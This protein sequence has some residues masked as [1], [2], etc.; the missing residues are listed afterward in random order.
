MKKNCDVVIIGAGP[1]GLTCAAYLA[2]AGLSVVVL[3]ARH[4]TGGGL[5]TLE[6]GGFKHNLHAIY[7]MM[8]EIMP[9][10][11]DFRLAEKGVRYIYPEVQA[12]YINPGEKPV[13]LYRDPERTAGY[14]SSAFGSDQGKNYARMYADFKEFSDK[15]L[16]PCTYV[17]SVPPIEQVQIL[18]RAKDDVGR[19]FNEVAELTPMEMLDQ[20]ELADPVRAAVLNLFT[21]WGLSPFEA[22]GYIFPLYVYRMTNA[23]LCAGGSHRLSSALYKTVLAAGGEIWDRMPV[24]RVILE[25]GRAAGVVT[26]DGT[27]IR[28]RAVAS[29]VDP[30]Q[31]FLTFF[32]ESEIP[33]HLVASAKRW[34]WEKSS[35]FGVHAALRQAP[36]YVGSD[37]YPDLNRA[38]VT[39]LG[40]RDTDALLDH[41]EDVEDGKLPD[42]PLGHVTCAS[43]FDPIQA[44]KGFATG[45]WE[46]SAPFDCDW[47]RI[48]GD[49]AQTCLETWKQ[50]APNLET[51]HTIVYPPSYIEKKMKNMVRGSIKQG[52]YIPLQMGYFRPNES[53]SQAW[54]PI[55]GYFVCGAS[56]YPGG[57]IIGGPGY[58]GANIVA[59]EL[60]AEKNW[61][62]PEIVRQARKAGIIAD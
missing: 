44:P 54:T 40:I 33:E 17:P 7:H 19:R 57:M 56:A 30:K 46:C 1:N 45:R 26:E 43:I 22:L 5:D 41:F 52:A 29:T 55:E 25:N 12:A 50:Y 49:Y 27:E 20:Y 3:E 48:K 47:D 62:E 13:I 58:I 18:E 8:A 61:E 28:A 34:E 59:E 10:H 31:N 15:I 23:A 60:G 4:E 6:F 39:F 2:R 14:L 16:I 51:L 32:E 37:E 38:M 21:M 42:T 53:C 24:V 9:A 36:V 35:L 11:Q